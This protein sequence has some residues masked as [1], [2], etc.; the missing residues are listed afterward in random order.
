[1]KRIEELDCLRGIASLSVVLFHFTT[2]FRN[3]YGVN[4]NDIIEMPH[5]KFGVELFFLISGFVIFM[6]LERSAK[7]LDFVVQRFSRIYPAYWFCVILD[8]TLIHVFSSDK[9]PHI[10]VGEGLVNLTM[11]QWFFKL[12][13]VNGVYW[14]L[15][16]ELTF[17]GF[18]TAVFTLRQL[19]NIRIIAI[20]WLLA[21][22]VA[23]YRIIMTPISI[24][25]NTSFGMFFVA[26][27]MFYKIWRGENTW[28][29]HALIAAS[30]AIA[31]IH[32]RGKPDMQ[33]DWGVLF[34]VFGI[35]Y[36]FVFG[37]LRWLV[38]VPTLLFFGKISYALYL[39]HQNVGFIIMDALQKA[40]LA[41]LA[42]TTIP[43][44]V[45]ISL[46][47]LITI[48]IEKPA[49]KVIRNFYQNHRKAETTPLS[50]LS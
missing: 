26:G 4:F 13:N 44:A 46:A 33:D 34:L 7:P 10:T 31:I 22:L 49:M 42:A 9:L 30:L 14:S 28:Q 29:N 19:K 45:C 27:I 24:G 6:S 41:S 15:V 17:Y 23:K 48:F 39:V 12:P 5:G 38:R 25:F 50:I 11:M 1:M 35:F 40:G 2:G 20:V 32:Y 37:K 18:M 36:L 21:C 47:W 3:V 8:F 43:L 16:R